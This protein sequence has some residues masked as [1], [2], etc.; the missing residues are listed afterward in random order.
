MR[1]IV[2]LCFFWL[3]FV[4]GCIYDT[5]TAIPIYPDNNNDYDCSTVIDISPFANKAVLAEVITHFKQN[6]YNNILCGNYYQDKVPENIKIFTILSFYS[7]LLNCENGKYLENRIIV[8]VREPGA[9]INGKLTYEQPRYFQAFSQEY[10]G[11]REITQEDIQNALTIAVKNLF[12]ID[13][14]RKSLEPPLS[15]SN[16]LPEIVTL[17]AN[18]YWE[19]SKYYQNKKVADFYEALR[20]AYFAAESGNKEAMKYLS[21][22]SL[23]DKY[24]LGLPEKYFNFIQNMANSGNAEAQNKLGEM[25]ENGEFV[26]MDQVAAYN[27]YQKSAAQGYVYAQYNLGRCYEYGYGVERNEYNAVHW[28]RL[29]AQQGLQDAIFKLK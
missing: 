26:S 15:T 23:N 6:N 13:E 8:L 29:A 18:G 1:N 16:L 22:N 2:L 4:S 20:F 24:I 3:F 28:Y 21:I 27:W 9:I 19:I 5:F 12:K 14:F 25:F 17:D 11:E 10:I 7:Q